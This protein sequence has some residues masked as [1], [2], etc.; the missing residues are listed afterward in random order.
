MIQKQAPA[1]IGRS[2]FD[3]L[4][5]DRFLST[6]GYNICGIMPLRDTTNGGRKPPLIKRR[7]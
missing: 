7:W 1:D 6:N 5:I 3:Y 4:S 2:L